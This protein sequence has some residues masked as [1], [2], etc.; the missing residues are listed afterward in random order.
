MFATPTIGSEKDPEAD[1]TAGIE[2]Q[3]DARHVSHHVSHL[4]A[5][6]IGLF[7]RHR[8]RGTQDAGQ[9][10][11]D[12]IDIIDKMIIT[13]KLLETDNTVKEIKVIV[14]KIL[15]KLHKTSNNIILGIR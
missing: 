8:S 7:L 9:M 15:G 2:D 4:D 11:I 10:T 14:G 3:T 1:N 6:I 13:N 5:D 12:S